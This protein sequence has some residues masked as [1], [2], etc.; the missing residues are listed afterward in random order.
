MAKKG[1][2]EII[3]LLSTGKTKTGENTGYFYTTVKNKRNTTGKLETV[4]F[5]RRAWNETAGRCGMHVP[6]KEK[7]LPPHK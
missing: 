4:K 3:M 7:K 6:F 2:R 5:D 1:A